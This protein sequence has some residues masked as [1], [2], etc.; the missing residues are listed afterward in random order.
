MLFLFVGLRC[1]CC[2]LCCDCCVLL[3]VCCLVCAV[4]VVV[5]GVVVVV[6][7]NSLCGVRCRCWCREQLSWLMFFVFAALV[8][9]D[10]VVVVVVVVVCVV[11]GFLCLFGML[12]VVCL[13]VWLID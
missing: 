6:G 9:F 11:G 13:F 1:V 3:I 7:R 8:I 4:S 2:V 5:G 12:F 10:A